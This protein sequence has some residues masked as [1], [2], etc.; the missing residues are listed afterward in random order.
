MRN[1]FTLALNLNGPLTEKQCQRRG[2]RI[3]KS[4]RYRAYRSRMLREAR[5]RGEPYPRF[6]NGRVMIEPT[7]MMDSRIWAIRIQSN[8][9]LLACP[10]GMPVEQWCLLADRALGRRLP[11]KDRE[12]GRA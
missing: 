5:R 4:M 6:P 12:R 8:R 10:D 11:R 1:P 7:P 2:E 3:E 9:E